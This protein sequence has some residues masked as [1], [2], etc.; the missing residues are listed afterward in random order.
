MSVGCRHDF[1]SVC[2]EIIIFVRNLEYTTMTRIYSFL[3]LLCLYL[4]VSCTYNKHVEPLLEE[5]ESL[6]QSSPDSAYRLLAALPVDS[7]GWSCGQVARYGLLLARATDKC[8]KPLLSCDSLLDVALEYYADNTPHRAMAL[9][10]KGRLEKEMGQQEEA[11]RMFQEAWTILKDKSGEAEM[12]RLVLSSLGNQYFDV[13][14]FDLALPLYRKLYQYSLTDKDKA[15]ALD[16]LCNYYALQENK[17]SVFA[18]RQKALHHARLSGDSLIVA[19]LLL[20]LS[21]DYNLFGSPD[22]TLIYARQA[23]ANVPCGENRSMYYYNLGDMLALNSESCDSAAYYLDRSR[24]G[25]ALGEKVMSLLSSSELAEQMGD[26]KAATEYLKLY[27]DY[28]DSLTFSEQTIKMENLIHEY[29][30]KMRVQEERV[31]NYSL[32]WGIISVAFGGCC[33]I[34]WYFMARLE[35]KKQRQKVYEQRLAYASEKMSV[36][37]RTIEDNNSII[38]LL[39]QKH[40]DLEEKSEKVENEIKKRESVIENLQEEKNNLQKWLFEQSAI[41]KK[42]IM[43]RQQSS[44][45][46]KQKVLTV[47][48]QKELKSIVFSLY[49]TYLNYLQGK[50]SRLTE[51]DLLLL[52]LKKTS[53]DNKSIAICFGYGDTHAINQRNLRIKERMRIIQD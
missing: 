14:S 10:Y 19:R 23:L 21:M 48:E 52:C 38:A 44:D 32:M 27:V 29:D 16:N 34:V 4:F 30:T 5:A 31:Q 3:T 6:V 42:I 51:D 1:C 33:L 24:E 45:S 20:S 47:V 36:L 37:Q 46:R 2:V 50:Y 53:L 39:Q 18:I 13:G 41:Y 8:M 11:T 35:K 40:Y 12:K 28:L 9:L 15:I 49:G 25:M 7:G 17:D 22:T 43:L 26:Y